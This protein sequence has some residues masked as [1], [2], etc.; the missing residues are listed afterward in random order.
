MAIAHVECHSAEAVDLDVNA[1]S[2]FERKWQLKGDTAFN[3][4]MKM[5]RTTKPAIDSQVL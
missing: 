4:V 1:H 2:C 3:L 5:T